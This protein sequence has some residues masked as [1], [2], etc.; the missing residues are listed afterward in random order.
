[1]ATGTTRLGLFLVLGIALLYTGLSLANTLTMSTSGRAAEFTA[2]RL[3]GAMRGQI[4][5]LT[6]LESLTVVAAGALLGLL[7]TFVT[8]AGTGAALGLLSAPA[9]LVLP[10]PAL[11][12]ATAGCALLA[13]VS[14]RSRRQRHCA[15]EN[16]SGDHRAGR[17]IEGPDDP[18]IIGALIAWT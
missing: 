10:W 17:M 4:L 9:P 3:A 13:V 11:G 15:A 18:K 5:R 14:S 2:L 12:A 6:A 7:V 16:E 1:M 8:W